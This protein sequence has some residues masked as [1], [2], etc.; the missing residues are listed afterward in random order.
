MNGGVAADPELDAS[1]FAVLV[2][3]LL[4]SDLGSQMGHTGRRVCYPASW[5]VTVGCGVRAAMV[6]SHLRTVA[7][8]GVRAM[9]RV[10]APSRARR[11]WSR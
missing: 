1:P 3:M 11:V 9:S 10:A 2:G 4:E 8:V 6:C 5:S 7:V